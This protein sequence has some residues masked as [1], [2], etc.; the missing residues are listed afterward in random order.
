MFGAIAEVF[1]LARDVFRS[2]VLGKH[3]REWKENKKEIRESLEHNDANRITAL[4]NKLREQGNSS[5]K[6]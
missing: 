4:F 3:D 1:G 6:R 2:R 5:E